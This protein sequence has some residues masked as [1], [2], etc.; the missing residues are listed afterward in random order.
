MHIKT[1]HSFDILNLLQEVVAGLPV[2]F[3]ALTG[4]VHW[5]QQDKF[6]IQIPW[7]L[8]RMR[9]NLS[10]VLL[11]YVRNICVN[12]R[13]VILNFFCCVVRNAVFSLYFVPFLFH[14]FIQIFIFCF[15]SFIL[16]FLTLSSFFHNFP[17]LHFLMTHFSLFVFIP[18]LLFLNFF[19][20]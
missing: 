6:W 1:S 14:T 16:S 7:R 4:H 8:M 15:C 2:A 10:Y 9:L 19:F 3:A 11:C 17:L 20:L 13:M 18:F 5:H 12:Y